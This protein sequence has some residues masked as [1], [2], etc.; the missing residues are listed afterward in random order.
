MTWVG[1]QRE[2]LNIRLEGKDIKQVKNVVYIWME[3]YLR[4]GELMWRCHAEYK[5]ERMQG[6]M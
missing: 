2:E 6:E 5:Q 4:M 1:K 3:I